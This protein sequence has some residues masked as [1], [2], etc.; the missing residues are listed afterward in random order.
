MSKS[1]FPRELA[2]TLFLL[3]VACA[4][5]LSAQSICKGTDFWLTLAN[6][7]TG[8]S[9]MEIKVVADAATTGTITSPAGLSVAFSV[10][11]GAPYTYVVPT[12]YAVS[13]YQTVQNLGLRVQTTAPVAVFTSSVTGG[14]GDATLV[15][16]TPSL[17]TE[18]RVATYYNLYQSTLQVV[19]PNNNTQVTF[20][21]PCASTSGSPANTPINVT[22][23]QGQTYCIAANCDLTGTLVTSTRPIQLLT[24]S[25]C[26][27][28]PS[29]IT[30]CDAIF[31]YAL[32]NN[33]WG[34]QYVTTPS[35]GRSC[36]DRY[37]IVA[38]NNAT[39]VY[40]NG[41]LVS[42]LNAGQFYEAILSG[43]NIFTASDKI[44]ISHYPISASSCGN[45]GDPAMVQLIPTDMWETSY[46]FATLN[47]TNI[48]S[49][50]L[51][52]VAR[53]AGTTSILLNGVP[54]AGWLPV[55][56][57]TSGYSYVIRSMPT[58]EYTLTGD[59]IFHGVMAGWGSYNS[60]ANIIGGAHPVII[61]PAEDW[62]LRG[63]YIPGKGNRLVGEV[64]GEMNGEWQL[65]RSTDASTPAS[66][67]AL[68]LGEGLDF[69]WLD[70]EVHAPSTWFYRL[71]HQSPNGEVTTGDWVAVSAQEGNLQ[72]QAY[73]NP[74]ESALHIE[75]TLDSDGPANL[76]LVNLTGKTLQEWTFNG[77]RG[78]N[79]K[80]IHLLGLDLPSGIYLLKLTA[81]GQT[82]HQTLIRK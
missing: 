65:E 20:V 3:M 70:A 39:A 1:P 24:G 45:A 32:P 61:L 8:N 14:S 63:E 60:Y 10:A 49:H 74:F 48:G 67:T 34:T 44:A 4:G 9:G 77:E 81:M 57:G 43:G 53:T 76:S 79:Q 2:L 16:P 62:K 37:R 68:S 6:N 38:L 52:I 33:Y 78:L 27:Q 80:E 23:N 56:S 22:L 40:R 13:T 72:L 66:R 30:Y 28:V 82:F 35:G 47:H 71:R 25:Y 73:P 50:F 29:G 46:R 19:A 15:Y 31:N 41:T 69:E 12:T 59:S 17:G 11:P 36:Q 64:S 42:T 26:A 21:L 58:G 5:S 54:V 75:F 18:F 7:L 51:T 55:A